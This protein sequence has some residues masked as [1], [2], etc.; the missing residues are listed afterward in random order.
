MTWLIIGAK[1]QL[2]QALSTVLREKSVSFSAFGSNELDITNALD[3]LNQII[4]V[5]PEVVINVAAWTDVDAAES[6]SIAAYAVNE[7][8]AQ[9]LAIAAKQVNAI[10][11]HI[12]TDYVFSGVASQ[13]WLENAVRQPLS[14]YGK[15]KAAGE[16]AVLRE[17]ASKTYIFRT[18]WLYSQWGR[19]FAKTMTRLAL[20]EHNEVKVVRDQVG[21][22]TSAVDVANQIV[23]S[24]EQQL[25]FGIYHATNSGETSWYEFAQLIFNFSGG[26]VQRITPI[27]STDF[28]R[29]A[30]RPRYSVLGH[31]A[32][33]N[34]GPSG[35]SVMPMREWRKALEESMP[36]IISEVQIAEGNI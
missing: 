13:P 7:I 14:V 4:K 11:A 21:Q 15:S 6:D 5:N 24:I 12:S 17:Y 32:W 27:S 10:F 36:S 34:V 18:A 1:G 3:C 29:P 33:R 23:T 8:G 16:V 35:R 28:V 9:N 26:S 30:Q 31:D 25:P 22:P 19:N 2:G 20:F